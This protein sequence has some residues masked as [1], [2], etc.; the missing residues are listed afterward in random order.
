MRPIAK[1]LWTPAQQAFAASLAKWTIGFWAAVYVVLTF[2]SVLTPQLPIG[3]LAMLRLPMMVVGVA[4]C[5]ALFALFDRLDRWTVL[6][7]AIA[8]PLLITVAAFCYSTV[9]FQLFYAGSDVVIAPA[10]AMTMIY[11]YVVEFVWIFV[12]WTALYYATRNRILSLSAKAA[13]PA[14]SGIWIK[15]G[16]S[17]VYLNPGQVNYVEAER[18]YVRIHTSEGS[19][20]VRATMTKM[21]EQLK[22]AGFVRIHRSVIAPGRRI[23]RVGRDPNGRI[24]A[25]LADGAVLPVGKAYLPALKNGS[26]VIG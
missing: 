11:S 14:N 20:L 10:K 3:T 9:N 24:V 12:A 22:D 23:R 7:R 13:T 4:L 6:R 21:E 5:A 17:N 2:R 8:V 19:H 1:P 25:T 18:D 26:G 16:S 15:D